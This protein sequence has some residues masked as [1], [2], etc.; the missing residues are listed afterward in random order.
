[1]KAH[2]SLIKNQDI[3]LNLNS[4]KRYVTDVKNTVISVKIAQKT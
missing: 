4:I 3:T 1:M 2:V